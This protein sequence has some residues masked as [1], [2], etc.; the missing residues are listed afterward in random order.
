[1]FVLPNRVPA[2]VLHASTLLSETAGD[3]CDAVCVAHV[4]V[5]KYDE[6]FIL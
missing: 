3:G 2:R 6:L 5:V 4:D 1:M